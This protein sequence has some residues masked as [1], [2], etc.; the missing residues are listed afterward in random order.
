ML[1]NR[2][3]WLLV[4]TGSLSL[5]LLGA[6]SIS[7]SPRDQNWGSSIGRNDGSTTATPPD[8]ATETSATDTTSGSATETM[9]DGAINPQ[10]TIDLDAVDGETQ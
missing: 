3:P 6:C 5:L 10:D 7:S 2:G 1:T 4:A 8:G 9:D